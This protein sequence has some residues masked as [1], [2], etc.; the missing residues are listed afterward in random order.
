MSRR[1][2]RRYHIGDADGIITASELKKASAQTQIE[3]MRDWF[4]ENFQDPVDCCPYESAEGGY[5]YFRGGPY[6]PHEVLEDEFGD[7]VRE[8]AIKELADEL[9]DISS[10]WEGQDRPGDFDEEADYFFESLARSKGTVDEFKS[11][12]ADIQQL[13]KI[14]GGANQQ[15]LTRLLYVNVITSL[16]AYLADFFISAIS[17]NEELKRLFVETNPDFQKQKF[18][19]SEIFEVR[20]G[21]DE[22]VKQYLVDVVWHHLARV[23]PMF[24]DALGVDFPED[25]GDL[26]TAV[27]IRHDIVHRNG[28]K[29]DGSEH[30]LEL[31]DIEALINRVEKLVGHIEGQAEKLKPPVI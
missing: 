28:K 27:Q 29:K 7:I 3:V 30:T 26:F 8:T 21:L 14:P 1:K 16:E 12:I 9:W 25:M 11:S 10:E 13:M 5:Q 18:S 24:R 20:E 19:L 23:K 4:Y 17:N 31:S 2:P 15:C 22:Q 6:E